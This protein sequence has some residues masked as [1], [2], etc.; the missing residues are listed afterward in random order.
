MALQMDR[1]EEVLLPDQR[2]LHGSVSTG[3]LAHWTGLYL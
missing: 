1:A 3:R 2:L